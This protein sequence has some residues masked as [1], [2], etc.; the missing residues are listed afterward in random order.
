MNHFIYEICSFYRPSF[1]NITFFYLYLFTQNMVSY[2]FTRFTNVWPATKHAFKCHNTYSEIIDS[3]RMIEPAHH[4]RCH[5]SGCTWGILCIFRS[6][7]SCYS[8]I[9][10]SNIT[11]IINY[12]I[13]WLNITMN[14]ILFMAIFKTSNKTSNEKS[15]KKLVNKI[16][17]YW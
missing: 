14:N 8:K 3:S 11:I 16:Q 17:T 7:N 12:K 1:W 5:I 13:F 2:F 4:L 10:Y 9:S 15:L 6:P